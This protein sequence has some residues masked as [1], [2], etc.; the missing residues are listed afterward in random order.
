MCRYVDISTAG[1]DICSRHAH[2]RV[3]ALLRPALYLRPVVSPACAGT[4]PGPRSTNTRPAHGDNTFT[5]DTARCRLQVDLKCPNPESTVPLHIICKSY[6]K[7][8]KNNIF[9]SNFLVMLNLANRG[10]LKNLSS[11]FSQQGNFSQ[12]NY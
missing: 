7:E 12:K 6:F 8:A 11:L 1:V 5:S 2:S 4:R 10:N 3:A 9:R